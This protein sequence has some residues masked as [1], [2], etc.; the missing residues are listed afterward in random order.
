MSKRVFFDF[1]YQDLA[2]FRANVVRNHW[3][4]KLDREPAGYF[5]ASVWE[6]AKK[7]GSLALNRH[8]NSA[9][10]NPPNTCVLIGSETFSRP[11]VR[12]ELFKS[13]AR[14]NHIFGVHVN[15]IPDKYRLSKHNGPNPFNYLAI[16]IS[17]DGG[18]AT[19]WHKPGGN[20]I[21]FNS[22]D[23]NS[24]VP[25]S[26]SNQFGAIIYLFSDIYETYDWV[27]DSGY[28][29]FSCWGKMMD[30]TPSQKLL[31]E[32]SPSVQAH[33]QIIQ[34]VIN[35]MAGNSSS[36]KTWC[37]TLVSAILVVIADKGKPDFAFIS[38]LPALLFCALDT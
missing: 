33:L 31:D 23:G 24:Q 12:Y 26:L 38:L 15:R 16:T 28:D 6:K 34:A 14:G 9:L 4:T 2:Y 30:K 25:V 11:W 18:M 20:W 17:M 37:I 1:H 10:Q 13:F 36:C 7:E 19:L 29:N 22:I 27:E 5:D 3:R 21:E 35:R 32:S 8:I